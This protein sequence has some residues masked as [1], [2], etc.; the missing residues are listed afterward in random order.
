MGVAIL[1]L[2]LILSGI[3]NNSWEDFKNKTRR[4]K[5][6]TTTLNPP[7]LI[8]M[9]EIIHYQAGNEFEDDRLG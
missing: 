8:K 4:E 1:F 5:F 2:L 6:N 3:V 9:E 7:K